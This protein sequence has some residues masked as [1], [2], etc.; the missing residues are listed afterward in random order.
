M[1]DADNVA[2]A[3]SAGDPPPHGLHPTP[4]AQGTLCPR[5]LDRFYVVGW[6]V[7]EMGQDPLVIQYLKAYSQIQIIT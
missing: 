1:C 7:Y 5:S 4:G 6:Q 3:E 2:A